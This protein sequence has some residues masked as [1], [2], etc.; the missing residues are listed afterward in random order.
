M[1]SPVLSA[2]DVR[3]GYSKADVLRGISFDLHAGEVL[4][5]I[6]PNGCGKSTMLR[7][8]T[9]LLGM[10]SGRVEIGG[11]DLVSLG[12]RERARICAVQPQTEAPVFDF[13]V[14]HFVLL[15]RHARRS[16]LGRASS[17]D[18]T[19][20]ENAL[21]C[22]DLRGLAERSVRELSAGEWQRALLAR[23]LAQET[24]VL[25]LDEPVA[26]LDPGHRHEVH[27]MLRDL[28]R[29]RDKAIL[30]VSHDLNLASGFCDRLMVMNNGAVRALGTPDEVLT[31]EILQEVFRCQSLRAGSNPFTGRPGVFFAS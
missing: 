27:A 3:A 2:K 29:N 15:G 14:R 16:L 28:A 23:A 1:K 4:G 7:T 22:A 26:H 13:G 31:D 18:M 5:V 24:P 6:G 12:A 25:M 9:G 30:C 17:A 19:A 10:R 21:A 8:L 11:R 20:A